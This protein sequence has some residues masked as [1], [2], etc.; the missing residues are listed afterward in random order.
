MGGEEER[1]TVWHVMEWYGM[2][3]YGM[4]WYGMAWRGMAWRGV[5][6]VWCGGARY[7]GMPRDATGC[8]EVLRRGAGR[9]RIDSQRS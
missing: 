8:G 3:W 9:G 5:A 2:V 4:V 6:L 7:G 1:G